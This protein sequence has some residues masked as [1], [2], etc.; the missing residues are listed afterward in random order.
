MLPMILS[1]F[2]QPVLLPEVLGFLQVEKDKKYIDA[3]LGGGGYT[4]KIIECGGIVL[5]IDKDIDAIEHVRRN[6]PDKI[7]SGP[8]AKL[9]IKHG[10]FSQIG[11]MA[12]E[13][14][15]EDISGIVF[16]L[17]ISTYQLE[18]SGRGF[19][20][21]SD[22]EIDMRMDKTSE[23]KAINLL[24]SL[25]RDKLYEIFTKNSE[26]LYSRAI[27]DAVVFTRTLKGEISKASDL[28]EIIKQLISKNT[29]GN[30]DGR[31]QKSAARIFQAL[32]IAVNKELENL[33]KALDASIYLLA[34]KG[35]IVVV[36]Y[37]S[38]EDRIVKKR[39]GLW[40]KEK[41]G[42]SLT[43]KP[44]FPSF[45]EIRNNPKAGSAKLRVFKKT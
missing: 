13:S 31:W 3:T 18:R 30:E 32:R 17:G 43:K 38:L 10:D 29:R 44:I 41:K 27:A 34:G 22:D 33:K 28:A 23:L 21:K 7:F 4:E 39:F 12:K 35:K 24:N 5:G 16:D 40:Y 9:T 8:K 20:F 26:E 14:G 36:S 37:H 25:S 1:S 2:H 15:F 45:S 19:S 11:K 42:K 6:F